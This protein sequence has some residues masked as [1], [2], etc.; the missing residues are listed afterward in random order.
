[1]K[2]KISILFLELYLIC[3]NGISQEIRLD[4]II[5]MDNYLLYFNI[6]NSQYLK[7]YSKSLNK[8]SYIYL[9]NLPIDSSGIQAR[10]NPTFIDGK[11][12][13]NANC[14]ENDLS[15]KQYN[16]R[17]IYY[18]IED[19]SIHFFDYEFYY[20]N[21]YKQYYVIDSLY[22]RLLVINPLTRSR[23]L[24]MDF[25]NYGEIETIEGKSYPLLAISKIFFL[26][27]DKALIQLCLL[28]NFEGCIG[29]KYYLGESD[30]MHEVTNMIKPNYNTEKYQEYYSEID[31]SAKQYLRERLE[32]R[33]KKFAD[34][35]MMNRLFDDNLK[36]ISNVLVLN[37]PVVLGV[38]I[39][40]KELQNHFLRSFLNNGV[41]VIIPYKFIPEL[42]LA[43]YKAY[44]NNTL[45]REDLKGFGK[46]ELD[47]LRNLIFAKYNY[48]FS[49]EFYQAYF[50]LYAFYNTPE[51]RN[52]R[53][54][55]INGKLTGADKAN[56]ELIKSME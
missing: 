50:N 48:D 41:K 21:N 18:T 43:M 6:Y 5:P 27:S 49:S 10:S 25:F 9:N 53:T 38:N 16:I 37:R 55:D 3:S 7:C 23:S 19:N 14:L 29:Y 44:N 42:D 22:W 15:I 2:I 56:L 40:N 45:T 31:F 24:F 28:G 34:N 4:T 1:M 46:Y 8:K 13:F 47:I 20:D 11:I 51:M 35:I 32:I 36:Y 26:N 54:K 12:F 33:G 30:N 52:S 17:K 39:K